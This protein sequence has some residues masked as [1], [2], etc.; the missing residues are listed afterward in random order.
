LVERGRA[1]TLYERTKLAAIDWG[2]TGPLVDLFSRQ[3]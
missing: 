2:V 1:L 3:R